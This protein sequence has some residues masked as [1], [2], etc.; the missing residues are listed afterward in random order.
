MV[1][2]FQSIHQ[3]TKRDNIKVILDAKQLNSNTDQ[4]IESRL[5]APL[6]SQL[7]RVARKKN[8]Q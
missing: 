6:A 1:Q 7:P 5:I 4:S 2:H 3:Y 8:L